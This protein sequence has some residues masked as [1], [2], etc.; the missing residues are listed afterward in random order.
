MGAGQSSSAIAAADTTDSFINGKSEAEDGVQVTRGGWRTDARGVCPTQLTLSHARG[1]ERFF[2]PV[3]L[4]RTVLP[5]TLGPIHWDINRS[6]ELQQA[7]DAFS[8]G[9]ILGVEFSVTLAD[10]CIPDC[11]LVACS[12]GFSKLTH[13]TLDEIIGKNCRFLLN[14]VPVDLIDEATRFK[15]RAF[16]ITAVD[17]YASQSR[18]DDDIPDGLKAEK[19]FVTLGKGEVLCIQANAKKSGELFRNMFFMKT[20]EL[21]DNPYIIG[22]QAGLP[23]DFEDEGVDSEKL[24]DACARAFSNLDENMSA[25]ESVLAQHFWYSAAM[26]RQL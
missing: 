13:Y 10:P 18:H 9:D 26:R 3:A 4:P 21:D 2:A 7:V 23:D 8:F 20:V 16:C 11:P 24:R 6:A 14:G 15:S 1:A 17:G 12:V 5:E 25:I 22:L 19:P